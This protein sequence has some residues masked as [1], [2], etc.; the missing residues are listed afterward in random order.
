ME[1]E[2]KFK[3]TDLSKIINQINILNNDFDLLYYRKFYSF[4]IDNKFSLLALNIIDFKKYNDLYGYDFGDQ[5]IY[6][7]GKYLKEYDKNI[8]CYPEICF[9]INSSTKEGLLS[10]RLLIRFCTSCLVRS[11]AIY[12]LI[13]SVK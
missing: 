12:C 9:G 2:I 4:E 7:T 1:R 11:S 8:T 10:L 13:I 3:E 6:A 5:L